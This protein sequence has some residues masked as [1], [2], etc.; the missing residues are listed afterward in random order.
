[1]LALNRK[2]L[3]DLVISSGLISKENSRS[4]IFD[5]PQCA[6]KDRL[7]F[8][9]E[10]GYFVCFSCRVT[11]GFQGRPEFG[12]AALLN[13]PVAS[14]KEQLY[15]ASG[16]RSPLH[17]V[18]NLRDF[19]G[20]NDEWDE[21][22]GE[23]VPMAYPF[24]FYPLEHKFAKRGL[25]YLEG[26]GVSLELAKVYDVRY[27]PATRRVIFPISVG[28]VIYG[29]QARAV[30]ETEVYDE[31]SGESF[32]APKI[33]TP[34]GVQ[35][36][37]MFMFQDRLIGSRHV[38]LGEGPMDAL[39]MHKVGGNVASMG[40]I[41]SESQL[42]I[43]RNAGVETVYLGLDN[44][45]STESNLVARKLSEMRV[46]DLRPP[47]GA[48]T[49]DGKKLAKDLGDMSVDDVYEASQRA[50][51]RSAG[52]LFGWLETDFATLL[53]HRRQSEKL[54]GFGKGGRSHPSLR[55]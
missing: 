55:R 24:D 7:Y 47:R 42:Q 21:D 16:Y 15:G 33:L 32:S 19:F 37:W 8:L 14:L 11:Q 46:L 35:R 45:A 9:K 44:D 22:A 4:W 25:T 41:I 31:E 26:R 53:R 12:L 10:T 36:E 18:S 28:G 40:K 23:L 6:K 51:E 38:A 5:C 48:L 54:R 49:R 52:K 3:E 50:P 30:F 43:L 20:D 17:L 1:M 2:V 13:R 27:C 34:K 39:K 29:W